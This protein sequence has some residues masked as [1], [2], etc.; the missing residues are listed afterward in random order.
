MIGMYS[1]WNTNPSE[2]NQAGD[3]DYA[4]I[5]D[6]SIGLIGSWNDLTNTGASSGPYQPKGYV[7]EYGGMPGDPE[8]N[9]SSS[10]S[11]S[12]PPSVTV[13]PFVGVD[14]ALISM[15]ASSDEEDA[16]LLYTSPSP[17]DLAVSRMPS[18]A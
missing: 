6:D 3:E 12:A 2:P 5:T 17:R 11:L 16:C 1:N 13:E 18:S 14:C 4:H 15:N 8:L 7:V 9:L 10:T